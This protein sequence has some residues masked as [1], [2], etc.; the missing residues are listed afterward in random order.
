MNHKFSQEHL[1]SNNRGDRLA[2]NTK[3]MKEKEPKI[4]YTVLFALHGTAEDCSKLEE[5]FKQCDIFVPELLGWS[6]STFDRFNQVSQG[7]IKPDETGISSYCNFPEMLIKTFE[8]IYRSNKPI[9]FIDFS[10]KEM[11]KEDH[12]RFSPLDK[13]FPL[14]MSNFLTGHLD[15]AIKTVRSCIDL[16]AKRYICRETKMKENLAKKIKEVIKNNPK[17]KDKSEIKVLISLGSIHTSFYHRLKKQCPTAR[18]KFNKSTYIYTF[19]NEAI[20]R[21]LF[22]KEPISDLLT[23][24]ALTEFI[25]Y[26]YLANFSDDNAKIIQITRQ[27]ISH[28]D[29]SDIKR[30]IKKSKGQEQKMQENILAR[31]KKKGVFVPTS[32]AKIDQLT[33]DRQKCRLVK[34][35]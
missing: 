6:Q 2:K 10:K 24:R 3:E 26:S 15:E 28:L 5:N 14:A 7:K 29:L 19:L 30:I 27:A 9:V 13:A 8:V 17:L 25:L 16:L 22:K 12:L 35:S 18:R 21:K 34:K 4:I 11:I 32:K 33:F 23:T 31:L 20:R 1:Q